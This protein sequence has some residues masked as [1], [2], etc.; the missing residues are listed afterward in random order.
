MTGFNLTE[1]F[2]S[3]YKN[4]KPKFGF[5]G[6]GELVYNRTYSRLKEN[7]SKEKWWETCKRVVEGTFSLQKRHILKYELGWDETK[8]HKSAED[9]FERMFSMKFLP[10]GRGLWAMGTDITEKR[11]LF[12]AL[13]NCAFTSTQNLDSNPTKPFEFLMDMSMLGVGVGFDVKGAGKIAINKPNGSVVF[14]VPDTREGWVE[15]LKMLLNS[16]FVENKPSIEFDYSQIRP[17]GTPIKTFGG[18][19][20]G[21]KPLESMHQAI[22]KVFE[23]KEGTNITITQ[24]TDVMNLIGACVVAGNV[25]RTAEI[26]FGQAD[27]EEY[28]KLK[29][30]RWDN[31][32][33]DYVGKSAHRASYGWTS[34]NSVFA[35]VGMDY[36]RVANQT[37]LNGEPGYAYLDNMQ[38]Y[39]RMV[40]GPDHKD[41]KAL[42]GNP[43]LEQTLESFELC[44]LVET[45]PTR[46]ETV[47][48]YKKT[49]K[50][51]YLYA[52][53]VTLGQ[54]HWPE[55]NRVMLR[56]R[57][58][59][60]SMSGVAQ[61]VDTRGLDTLKTWC[62]EGYDVIQKYDE[63]YSDW[64]CIPRSIKTT[65]IKP[66]GTVSLLPGVTPGMHWPE[67]NYY[68]RRVTLAKNSE[69][70]TK[71]VEAGY[72][73]EE[74][75]SSPT[76]SVVV[77]V[78]VYIE[79]VRT[80][81][82]VSMW[83]QM[84]LAAFL[85]KYWADNQVSST[86]TFQ[87]H[88]GSQIKN[89]LNYFQYQLKGISFL[90]KLEIGAFPQM[91][92][93]QC[94]KEVYDTKLSLLTELNFDNVTED[95]SPELYCDSE[96]CEIA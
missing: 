38:K 81:D 10:P 13:N 53:T 66:S 91:P 85:Q 70:A 31:D 73:V 23:G 57:R 5:N 86:I 63:I 55:T 92:Y 68:I 8:A 47:E 6:L 88:E 80:I 7:G 21:S 3:H 32:K 52:K 19:S 74:S 44:C 89:A 20:S 50:S 12:A 28:L 2:L 45:F 26:V 16:Y 41:H 60:T 11:G 62:N 84:S 79:G 18:T 87:K 43:C 78:P 36:T 37:A 54:T 15:S 61:F 9:M 71:C 93:E 17:E 83:E 29:D 24:I 48:D 76:T 59:G 69:L 58:I 72:K 1:G 56:N 51:A 94:S 34:N 30:Y 67:S 65:S 33:G 39:G 49:L 27:N 64:L 40:D 75:M 42:G 95:S 14:S 25:R 90:P 4:K 77:E 96:K 22:V 46:H 82:E 35:E